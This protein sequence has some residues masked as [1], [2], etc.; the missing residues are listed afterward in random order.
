MAPE[1]LY[2]LLQR[3]LVRARRQDLGGARSD[4]EALEQTGALERSE[5][6]HALLDAL[7]GRA[8]DALARYQEAGSLDTA[9]EWARMLVVL[10]EDEEALDLLTQAVVQP[11]NLR[12]PFLIP[13]RS[14]PRFRALQERYEGALWR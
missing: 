12:D 7:E 2:G 3:G 9:A 11:E 14:H 6:L 8:E 1:Y 13:I 4:A 10:G 5:P